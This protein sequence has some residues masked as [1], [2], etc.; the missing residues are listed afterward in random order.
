[1]TPVV[2]GNGQAS[3]GPASTDG[4]GPGERVVATA[5]GTLCYRLAPLPLPGDRGLPVTV[6]ATDRALYLR[7]HGEPRST[8][9]SYWTLGEPRLRRVRPGPRRQPHAVLELTGLSLSGRP[10]YLRLGRPGQP[11]A[12]DL[13]TGFVDQCRRAWTAF[14]GYRG[15]R[16]PF[17]AARALPYPAVHDRIR[18]YLE[19]TRAHWY[20]R[21]VLVREHG[22][23]VLGDAYQFS[24]AGLPVQ[25]KLRPTGEPGPVVAVTAPVL[26]GIS[27]RPSAGPALL[28][29][30]S[31]VD[32]RD[33][34]LRVTTTG[35]RTDLYAVALVTAR[36]LATVDLA[37]GVHAV[38]RA[39]LRAW[40]LRG[41]LGGDPAGPDGGTPA[42]TA[43][44]AASVPVGPW[45][46]RVVPAGADRLLARLMSTM[47]SLGYDEDTDLLPDLLRV[48][49][50]LVTCH[51]IGTLPCAGFRL[52]LSP[53]GPAEALPADLGHRLLTGRGPAPEV[54]VSGDAT[55]D[56]RPGRPGSYA[57]LHRPGRLACHEDMR[58]SVE[59]LL[60]RLTG[61]GTRGR[62]V[63]AGLPIL[64]ELTPRS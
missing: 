13:G 12:L 17:A 8:R 58:T 34:A 7:L 44:L 56:A 43:G 18:T 11:D 61:A 35:G 59:A 16:P 48:G 60:H 9:H 22:S 64:P 31:Q 46:E 15:D 50:L 45:P 30:A 23:G 5:E 6:A 32:P 26:A 63:P 41:V 4:P 47:E 57:Y 42:W 37:V 62:P 36:A 51:R 28:H 29:L 27:V 24:L 54:M 25:V 40:G 52:V 3:T 10:V 33:G 19:L 1:M 21:P 53:P 38:H 49:N 55:F 2:P 20:D 14:R 39:A